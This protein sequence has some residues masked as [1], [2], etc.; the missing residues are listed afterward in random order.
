MLCFRRGV[1]TDLSLPLIHLD[2][3]FSFSFFSKARVHD[4]LFF[5]R[6]TL[7]RGTFFWSKM[8]RF[9]P[10]TFT[11]S[12]ILAY[13]DALWSLHWPN[14]F[15]FFLHLS[16]HWIPLEPIPLFLC[17]GSVET[18]PH[19]YLHLFVPNSSL[20]F[21]TAGPVLLLGILDMYTYGWFMLMSGRNQHNSVK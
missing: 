4:I 10:F 11:M 18:L 21:L 20:L 15:F 14:I 6:Q 16:C 12:L 5:G 17:P 8:F 19:T 9:M 13:R 2:Q 7:Q 3:F 1:Q